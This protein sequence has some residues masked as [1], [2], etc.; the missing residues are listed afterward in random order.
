MNKG[1][2]RSSFALVAMVTLVA[3]AT[4]LAA[5]APAASISR[6]Y[7]CQVIGDVVQVV[8]SN[9]TA[10]PATFDVEV[11]AVVNG[12]VATADAS[13]T[14]EPGETAVASIVFGSRVN[15]VVRSDVIRLG[16]IGDS[17]N[18]F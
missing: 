8:V 4:T 7:G 10:L 5:A 15:S 13:V 14:L 9:P 11:E 1:R 18:P 12:D 16:A 2:R 6:S 3:A 17:P